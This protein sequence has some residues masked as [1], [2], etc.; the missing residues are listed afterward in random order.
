MGLASL[1]TAAIP[2]PSGVELERFVALRVIAYSKNYNSFMQ[3]LMPLEQGVCAAN[4]PLDLVRALII[5]AHS[6]NA[7]IN[8]IARN[9]LRSVKNEIIVPLVLELVMRQEPEIKLAAVAIIRELPWEAPIQ[10]AALRA[11]TNSELRIRQLAVG[12]IRHW[13]GNNSC[14]WNFMER[15]WAIIEDEGQPWYVR[16]AAINTLKPKWHTSEVR[17]RL[18]LIISTQN[19]RVSCAAIRAIEAP[20]AGNGSS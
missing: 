9:R 2:H 14:P 10:D 17:N 11:K 3:A 15:L 5:A 8:H 19:E 18:W 13:V 16:V 12:V 4:Y 1:N 20:A 7:D 6:E